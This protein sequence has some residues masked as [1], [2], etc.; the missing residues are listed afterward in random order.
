[1]HFAICCMR[2]KLKQNGYIRILNFV[3]EY[4]YD[5]VDKIGLTKLLKLT[6]T[7]NKFSLDQKLRIKF[8]FFLSL[9]HYHHIENKTEMDQRS[10]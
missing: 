5:L 2:S 9:Q 8:F 4:L 1:M 6:K 10:W 7:A 3:I